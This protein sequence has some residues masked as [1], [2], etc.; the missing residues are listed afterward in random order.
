M[1]RIVLISPGPPYRGGISTHSSLLYKE[2]SK[3]NHVSFINYIRQYPSFL[4]PGKNQYSKNNSSIQTTRILDSINPFTWF[5]TV[6][7]IKSLK[8]DVVMVRYWQPFFAICLLIR[9]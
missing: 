5:K 7:Y 8:P 9:M 1:T 6:K 3:K 2:L 4:F